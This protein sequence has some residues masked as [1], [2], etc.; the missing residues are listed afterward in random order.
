VELLLNLVWLAA[1]VT[2]LAAALRQA[3][4]T[5]RWDRR[6]QI[7]TVALCLLVV[8]F[9]VISMSDDLRQASF[10]AEERIRGWA[11]SLFVDLPAVFPVP[12]VALLLA[13]MLRVALGSIRRSTWGSSVVSGFARLVDSRPPP[14]ALLRV[15]H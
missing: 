14:C 12:A 5:G 1:A 2:V 10:T 13:L 11:A 3:C 4:R 8:L 7:L 6:F 15:A 9:P